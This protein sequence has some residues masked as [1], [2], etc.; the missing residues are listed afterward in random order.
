M[1]KWE[2][3]QI[4]YSNE[5]QVIGFMLDYDYKAELM[6]AEKGWIIPQIV[7]PEAAFLNAYFCGIAVVGPSVWLKDNHFIG[8]TKTTSDNESIL[9]NISSGRIKSI[10]KKEQFH[11]TN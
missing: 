9:K 10:P 11:I 4:S 7:G 6:I 1:E 2:K 3:L 8:I 5:V